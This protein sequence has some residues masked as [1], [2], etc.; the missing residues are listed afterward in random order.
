[1]EE[2]A[3]RLLY[4]AASETPAPPLFC[5]AAIEIFP[6]INDISCSQPHYPKNK[7]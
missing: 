7:S 6:Q 3:S 2:Q 4:Q 1:M 5:Y